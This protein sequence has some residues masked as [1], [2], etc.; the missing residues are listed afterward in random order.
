MTKLPIALAI[1]SLVVASSTLGAPA[2]FAATGVHASIARHAA[3]PKA[4]TYGK[5]YALPA[6][7][8]QPRD[9]DPFADMNLG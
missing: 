9:R 5:G 8:V 2:A 7:T 4:R 6:Q 1:A 3:A